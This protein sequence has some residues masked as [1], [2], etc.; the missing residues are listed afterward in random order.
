[1]ETTTAFTSTP[2]TS[3]THRTP[4]PAVF[5]MPQ[6]KQA[7]HHKILFATNPSLLLDIAGKQT[8]PM[9]HTAFNQYMEQQGVEPSTGAPPKGQMERML[10]TL[11]KVIDKT[12]DLGRF[13]LDEED[14]DME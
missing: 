9:I 1:M 2:A 4:C 6:G 11:L 5:I 13:G 10:E 12:A 8:G 3:G 7:G 14:S